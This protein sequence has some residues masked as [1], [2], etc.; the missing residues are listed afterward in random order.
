MIEKNLPELI[1]LKRLIDEGGR[2]LEVAAPCSI[3]IDGRDF[4]GRR[5]LRWATPAPMCPCWDSLAA[6]MGW[7]ASA[8]SDPR[9]FAKLLA[10]LQWIA[11]CISNSN[12]CAWC[13]CR[14]SIRAGCGKARAA[15]EGVELMRNA[16]LSASEP[17]LFCWAASA[18]ATSC[19]G[20][21]AGKARR[22]RW[23]AMP[24][25]R[26]SNANCCRASSASPSIAIPASACATA[27][28]FRTPTPPRRSPTWPISAR[29]KN[30]IAAPIPTTTMYRAAKPAIPHPWRPVGLSVPAGTGDSERVFLPLTL[31]MGSWLWS[32]KTRASCSTAPASSTPRPPT[33]C[34][35]CCAAIWCGSIF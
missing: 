29:W 19:P 31:E 4:P 1:M 35:A 10:R 13:L 18:T 24:Y 33:A 15:T 30:C 26:W 3:P 8:T 28:G 20:T 25:A 5:P 27:S 14:W 22:C 32:R 9:L 11:A 2:H 12:R 23:K 21:G 7:S 34:S 6:S 17:C 16:L